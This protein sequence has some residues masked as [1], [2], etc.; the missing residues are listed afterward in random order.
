MIWCPIL[1]RNLKDHVVPQLLL[2]IDLL[3]AYHVVERGEDE[4]VWMASKDGRFSVTSFFMA[5][6]NSRREKSAVSSI[7][8]L[9]APPRVVIFGWLALRKRILTMDD[10][11]RRGRIVVNGCPMCL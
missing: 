8:K 7:W 2:L 10:L 3:T 9:K 1:R 4:R 11:K 5:L 6:S